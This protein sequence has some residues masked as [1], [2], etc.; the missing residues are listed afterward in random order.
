M[1]K[2]ILIT[3]AIFLYVMLDILR[4]G[5]VATM[6]IYLIGIA[7]YLLLRW[8]IPKSEPRPAPPKPTE[9]EKLRTARTLADAD[10]RG[11]VY[12][13]DL[14]KIYPQCKKI[15]FAHAY[16]PTT[17]MGY[18]TDRRGRK[19]TYLYFCYGCEYLYSVLAKDKN[20]HNWNT[21]PL[22]IP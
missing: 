6:C 10:P 2:N 8:L 1:T 3:I 9:A 7:I 22:F 18:D 13:S 21:D 11:R 4:H 14:L 17:E 5:I 15:D 16:M 19:R 20:P 12:I